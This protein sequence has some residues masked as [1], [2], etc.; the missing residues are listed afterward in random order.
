MSNLIGHPVKLYKLFNKIGFRLLGHPPPA[1]AGRNGIYGYHSKFKDKK[2]NYIHCDLF[3]TYWG[4]FNVK[5]K[6][7]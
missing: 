5:R 1:E 2:T 7:I 6:Y 4:M 3:G